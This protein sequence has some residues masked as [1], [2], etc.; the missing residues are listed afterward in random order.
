G[1]GGLSDDD[2]YS[3]IGEKRLLRRQCEAVLPDSFFD[4]PKRG[5]EF[6]MDSWMRGPLRGLVESRL[7]DAEQCLAMGLRAEEVA[8]L[9]RRFLE[10]PGAIYWTRPWAVFSLL[11]WASGNGVRC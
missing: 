4:R 7:L 6:P 8:K 1:F 3:P 10:T 11:Q 9:W 2:R 5:F